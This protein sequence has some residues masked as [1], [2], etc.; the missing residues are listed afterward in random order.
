VHTQRERETDRE[1]ERDRDREDTHTQRKRERT[2]ENKKI[3]RPLK[4]SHWMIRENI[5]GKSR[6][7]GSYASVS[8]SSLEQLVYT[9]LSGPST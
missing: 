8:T 4:K 1:R 3:T 7:C 2:G 5:F 9:V 6:L